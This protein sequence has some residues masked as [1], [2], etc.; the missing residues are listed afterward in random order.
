MVG[1]QQSAE[2]LNADDLTLAAIMLWLD[3]LIEALMDPLM[4]I[5][6]EVYRAQDGG[7]SAAA[8]TAPSSPAPKAHEAV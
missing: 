4:M 1:L 3:D 6:L 2:A 7:R 5:V 8:F